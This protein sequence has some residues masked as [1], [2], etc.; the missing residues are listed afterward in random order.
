MAT[1][2]H[3]KHCEGGYEEMPGWM[4]A[5]RDCRRLEDLPPEARAY[6]SRL[7]ELSG[8]PVQGI[9]V[10]PDREHTIVLRS[11]IP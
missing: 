2:S 11:L 10:G 1:I 7:G 4:T 6:I 8:A 3:R 9:S 5:T